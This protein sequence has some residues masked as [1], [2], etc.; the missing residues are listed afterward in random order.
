MN[1]TV[2]DIIFTGTFVKGVDISAAKADLAKLFKVDGNRIDSIFKSKGTV[3]KKKVDQQTALN[4]V[5]ILNKFGVVC[6]MRERESRGK[7]ENDGNTKHQKGAGKTEINVISPK[8]DGIELAFS[9]IKANRITAGPNGI[10][11]NRLGMDHVSFQEILLVSAFK[12]ESDDDIQALIFVSS[13]QRPFIFK[14]SQVVYTDF[15]D[16]NN[17][18]LAASFR[19][20]LTLLCNQNPGL[21][22][23]ENTASFISG[24]PPVIFDQDIGKLTTALGKKIPDLDVP[25]RTETIP[26]LQEP[27]STAPE[28]VISIHEK[29]SEYQENYIKCPKC[30]GNRASDTEACPKCGL[31]FANWKSDSGTAPSGPAAKTGTEKMKPVEVNFESLFEKGKI[32]TRRGAFIFSMMLIAGFFLPLFK[33]SLLF[34]SSVV[35]WP[36]QILGWGRETATIA[37]TATVSEGKHLVL[38]GIL[39]LIAG[40]AVLALRKIQSSRVL[41][42]GMLF[43]GAVVLILM[44]TVFIAEGEV[45]GLFIV[46]PTSAG[47][48]MILVAVTAGALIAIANHL[49]KDFP[50]QLLPRVLSGS[51]AIVLGLCVT[52]ALLGAGS[53]PW[54][55]GAM[56]LLYLGLML[57]AVSGV[58]NAIQPSASD[59]LLNQTSF[60]ARTILCYAPIACMLSQRFTSDPIVSYVIGSGGGLPNIFIS[61]VKVFLI[62]YGSAFMTA[63]G[64]AGLLEHRLLKNL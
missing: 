47:G 17:A 54:R 35:V 7:A 44:E 8:I 3:I 27:T 9:P 50:E 5:N 23:D 28:S 13:H 25:S 29:K 53:G 11:L 57:Y 4:Y 6:M 20:F 2:Y 61:I 32:W 26:A 64:F 22:L 16:V 59:S 45:L 42:M 46:P 33:Y 52:L 34:G 55:G 41:N 58:V 39:P 38:W 40:T 56:I 37:A 19:N 36:W 24:N 43:T 51:G 63:M 10:D 49:R 60:L 21:A 12:E 30:G 48:I 18:S 15:A 31:V 1:E 14:A 62:Y